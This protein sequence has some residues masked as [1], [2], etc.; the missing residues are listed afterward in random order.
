[1]RIGVSKLGRLN[2][3]GAGGE[4]IVYSTN[5]F[6]NLVFKEF[7]PEVARELNVDE[8]SNLVG[9]F[10]T[11]P[12]LS[13]DWLRERTVWP[14][15]LV[16]RRGRCVGF[17][18]PRIPKEFR[19]RYGIRSNPKMVELE[20]NRL[21]RRSANSNI[22]S[23]VPTPAELELVDLVRDLYLTAQHLHDA[24]VVI[25]DIS[26]R[27]LLWRLNPV[28]QVLFIDND[29]FRLERR[30]GVLRPKES[31]DWEDPTVS[32]AQTS[33]ASDLYKLA[34]ASYRALWGRS[35]RPSRIPDEQASW[36]E[37][38]HLLWPLL[39]ETIHA[40]ARP[41]LRD[42][43]EALEK[44]RQS[45]LLR[46]RPVLPVATVSVRPQA[47]A[48]LPRPTRPVLSLRPKPGTADS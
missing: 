38:Q 19:A 6:P 32:G 27:N 23:E 3:L 7:K 15:A 44:A 39:A 14:C 13:Q 37:P 45:L 24:G 4:G 10:A 42:W 29:G 22:V 36:T 30:S 34:L 40:V 18:M 5:A 48:L 43:L 9:H 41:G 28:P 31:P 8:L 11:L 25:G 26:G 17:L 47:S 33:R 1:M 46:G 2:Q 12:A 35:G 20:W 21:V 16:E